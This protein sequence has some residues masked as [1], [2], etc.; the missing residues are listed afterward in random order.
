MKEALA[1]APGLGCT[2]ELFAAQAKALGSAREVVFVDTTQ[3]ETLA[4]MAAQFLSAAPPRFALAGLSMGGYL[5]LEIARMAPTRVTRLALMDTSAR[6]DDEGATERRRRLIALAEAGKLA[7]VHTVLWEKLVHQDRLDD[8][9]L[10]ETV[11]RMLLEIGPEAFVRQQRAI[12]GR[13]DSRPTLSSIRVPTLV[14]VGEDDLITPPEV[15]SELAEGIP[16][17]RIE[18]VPECGHL[19]SLERPDHVSAALARWLQAEGE[20]TAGREESA[21]GRAEITKRR[22][23]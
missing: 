7:Q 12:I 8:R 13:M 19:S 3:A 17:A 9:D 20:E 23:T 18:I 2:P 6:P 4:A 21:S 14:L 15:A 5:A 10:E 1:F 11:R 16:F 22:D